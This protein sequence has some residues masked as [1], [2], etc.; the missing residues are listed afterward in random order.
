MAF[1]YRHKNMLMFFGLLFSTLVCALI[2]VK[3]DKTNWKKVFKTSWFCPALTGLSSALSNVFILLLIK[4]KMSSSIIYPGIAVGGLIITILVSLL[5][6]EEK[7]RKM[8][9]CGIA[10]GSVA[11]V[12]LNL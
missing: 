4:Y 12:L 9:W 3:E 10:V 2:S 7:L 6:F 1:D 5:F 11:L 8:Q